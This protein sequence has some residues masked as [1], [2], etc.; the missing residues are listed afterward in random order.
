MS[1]LSQQYPGYSLLLT[2][3]SLGA[4]V[5]ALLTHMLCTT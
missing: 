4:G 5:A 2:G 3:H 1:K